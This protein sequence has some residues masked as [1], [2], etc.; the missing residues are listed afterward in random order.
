MDELISKEINLRIAEIYRNIERL[1][2]AHPN[3]PEQVIGQMLH[4]QVSH[5]EIPEDFKLQDTHQ[6]IDMA[7][8]SG[9]VD[10]VK[11]MIEEV[12]QE[13]IEPP[14]IFR[15]IPDPGWRA[16]KEEEE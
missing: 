14:Q 15:I 12:Y 10:F 4:E 13:N 16:L 6:W 5:I 3:I 7:D 9:N 2:R 11:A 1:R 8:V